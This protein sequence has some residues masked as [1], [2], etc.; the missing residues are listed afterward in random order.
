MIQGEFQIAFKAELCVV[1]RKFSLFRTRRVRL[2]YN[3]PILHV[4]HATTY[5]CYYVCICP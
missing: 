3:T 1:F 2:K 4:V 5:I